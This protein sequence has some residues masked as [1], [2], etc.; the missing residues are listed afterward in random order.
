M[1]TKCGQTITLNDDI[2]EHSETGWWCNAQRGD[3]A[4]VTKRT[5][6][7][8]L[9][10]RPLKKPTIG[11]WI[12]NS[13]KSKVVRA[14]G[15]ACG[16]GPKCSCSYCSGNG[17]VGEKGTCRWPV[18]TLPPAAQSWSMQPHAA[19]ATSRVDLE[20][21]LSYEVAENQRL[22]KELADALAQK[23]VFE[24]A[25][26]AAVSDAYDA[27]EVAYE[28]RMELENQRLKKELADALAQKD[29]FE[30]AAKAAVSDAY[31]AEEAAYEARAELAAAL[32]PSTEVLP[33]PPKAWFDQPRRLRQ[34]EC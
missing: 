5:E 25:A 13:P 22:K 30:H 1:P 11:F 10:V 23:D 29:V 12:R 4:K 32:K 27:E 19:C 28:A 20:S 26:K 15:G 3:L 8:W 7:G 17:P 2:F 16:G 6:N 33:Q 18:K 9:F 14:G 21:N 31:D 24:H 34:S